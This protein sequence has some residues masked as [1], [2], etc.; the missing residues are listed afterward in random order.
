MRCVETRKHIHPPGPDKLRFASTYML[1]SYP[2]ALKRADKLK[3]PVL[4]AV[5][6]DAA[7]TGPDNNTQSV[8]LKFV[9]GR[10]NQPRTVPF[11]NNS[12]GIGKT[13]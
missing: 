2:R 3:T 9:Q 8:L 11:F 4:A 10:G 5:Q 6:A 12:N 1:G 13:S 7:K